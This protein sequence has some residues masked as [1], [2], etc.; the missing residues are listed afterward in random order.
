M[1]ILPK[2]QYQQSKVTSL[3]QEIGKQFASRQ[4]IVEFRA[5]SQLQLYG[6][7]RNFP[8]EKFK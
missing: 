2:T 5:V 3:T 8:T 4:R 7:E 6:Q 1:L